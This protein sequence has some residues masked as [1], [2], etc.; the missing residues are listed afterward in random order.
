MN[1][2]GTSGFLK[3]IRRMAEEVSSR[4]GC[5]LY[6]LD[7]VGAVGGRALRIFIEKDDVGG[8]SL[9]DCSKV[10]RGLNLLLDAEDLVPGESYHLEVSSPGLERVLKEPR[11]FSKALGKRISVKTFVPL[12]QF[13]ESFPE[14]GKAK[15]IV[16]TLL[17]FDDLGL[18]LELD[19]RQVF[20]PFESITK[21]HVVY[22]FSD[23]PDSS[24]GSKG[25]VPKHPSKKDKTKES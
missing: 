21:A 20:V 10:S 25:K 13:N 5:Y 2:S 3:E 9:E 17:S 11:H 18:R 7:F 24:K 19:G 8:V 14:L 16:G 4:E 22:E 23:L 12:L 15:Q 1:S 6:D